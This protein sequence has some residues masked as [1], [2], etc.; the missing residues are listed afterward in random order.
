MMGRRMQPEFQMRTYKVVRQNNN[1]GQQEIVKIW[2]G[3]DLLW[4]RPGDSFV[5]VNQ[6]MVKL[7][8]LTDVQ[9]VE[10]YRKAHE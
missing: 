6:E 7:S 3:G 2:D 5:E 1:D 8:S 4:E 9:I 10:L